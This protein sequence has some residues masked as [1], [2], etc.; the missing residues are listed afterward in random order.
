MVWRCKTCKKM[1]NEG[2]YI[3]KNGKVII[4]EIECEPCREKRIRSKWKYSK[5]YPVTIIQKGLPG[6]RPKDTHT[7]PLFFTPTIPILPKGNQDYL[8][9]DPDKY[10]A[11]LGHIKKG[12]KIKLSFYWDERGILRIKEIGV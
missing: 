1:G 9:V 2:L 11:E 10:E 5:V 6:R 8:Y 7:I 12:T 4:D 3:T